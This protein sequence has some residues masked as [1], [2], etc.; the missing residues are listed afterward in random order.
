MNMGTLVGFSSQTAVMGTH[1]CIPQL[2]YSVATSALLEYVDY[3]NKDSDTWYMNDYIVNLVRLPIHLY[4]VYVYCP[5]YF[6]ELLE[7]I[8]PMPV[9]SSSFLI[10]TALQQTIFSY[11]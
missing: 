3:S 9:L 1:D 7:P 5:E 11:L 8:W 4:G 10:S 2:E 6:A